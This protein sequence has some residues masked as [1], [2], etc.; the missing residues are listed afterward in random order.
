MQATVQSQDGILP[1]AAAELFRRLSHAET[2]AEAAGVAGFSAYRVR[3]SF[4]EIYR[5]S[6]FDLL[7]GPVS[8]SRD[9]SSAC[10]LR[11]DQDGR[12]YAEGAYEEHVRSAVQL[13]KVVARGARARSTAATGVH[14]HSS[15]SHAMLVLT[16]EHRWR[17][18]QE[19]DPTKVK[20]QTSR[21]TLVDLA[22]AEGMERAHDGNVDLAGVGTNIGLLVLGRVLH[23]LASGL[24]VPYRDS[25]LTRLMQSGLGGNAK[26]HML[27]CVSPAFAD[28]AIS[29]QTLQYASSAMTVRLQVSEVDV[30]EEIEEDPMAGDFE[31]EDSDLRRRTIWIETQFGDVF[32]R[33]A[34]DASDPLLLYIHGS[35]SRN[36]S[37]MWN[38]LVLD[39]T[40]LAKE[41]N[42]SECPAKFYH[43]AIDCPGYGRS[44]GNR[45]TI[46]SF[47][48][49]LIA[50]I[51]KGLSRRSVAALIGSS[52]GACA[53]FNFALEYRDMS[54]TLAVCHPVG[55]APQRYEAIFQPALL[56]F[57]VEDEGHPVSVGRQMRRYLQDP[58][59]FEFAKSQDGDWE[60]LHMG[61]EVLNMFHGSWKNFQ[62]RKRGGRR[63]DRLPELTR[64][65][66]GF[67]SWSEVHNDEWLPWCGIGAQ[68]V[69]TEGA[70]DVE[71]DTE[72]WE[73]LIDPSSNMVMYR[74]VANGRCTK[75]RPRRGHVVVDRLHAN[76]P[77]DGSSH[78]AKKHSHPGVRKGGPSK[79][80]T[81]ALF[82]TSD[83]E[84]SDEIEER[85]EQEAKQAAEQ[86]RREL[87]QDTCDACGK[88]VVE[89][90]RLAICRCAVCACCSERTIRYTR[91]CPVCGKDI[92]MDGKVPAQ[93]PGR[94]EWLDHLRQISGDSA[95]VA[96]ENQHSFLSLLQQIR[97]TMSRFVIEYGSITVQGGSKTNWTSFVK[98]VSPV[99]FKS[100]ITKVEFNINP[101]FN[102]P[103]AIV[104][105]ATKKNGF[106]FEYAMARSYPCYMTVYFQGDLSLPRL[107]IE[108][109]VQEVSRLSRRI[110]V[111]FPG[112]KCLFRPADRPI[113]FDADPPRNGWLR[114][115]GRKA[116]IEYLPEPQWDGIPTPFYSVPGQS[117]PDLS[118][119]GADGEASEKKDTRKS[120]K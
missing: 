60:C 5:E 68:M 92:K 32:A 114:C 51:I 29:L 82:D 102:K 6:V 44:P 54:H 23:A 50:S 26:T 76:S 46:R 98:V 109:E 10:G 113:I 33:C 35:G 100:V 61:E 34:G 8:A 14:A 41:K 21:F 117:L 30:V 31:D 112:S 52:Q 47:P 103:T 65:G 55:H 120:R 42:S 73:V 99:V 40:R 22:G 45:Q 70:L 36:S 87:E 16:V 91:Q 27:A 17:D 111:Q 58:R 7:A 24:R 118:T 63:D 48:G 67:K 116:E 18:G 11:E 9:P 64:E 77:P 12:V 79:P 89:P 25:T 78:P 13:L 74:N 39:I 85:K 62:K 106:S 81:S 15:R 101:G 53:T 115:A 69:E 90:L 2:D 66:G 97:S 95:N 108:F 105:E 49:D 1:R 88:P 19:T 84:Y 119:F 104:T 20:S 71:S 59:Y 4:L 3:A 83:S 86:T 75:V 94:E 57:D 37:M 56:I 96:E 80:Y 72:T 110:V 43:V 38:E 107:Q 93:A 28:A